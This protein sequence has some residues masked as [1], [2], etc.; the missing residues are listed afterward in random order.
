VSVA[1]VIAASCLPIVVA[2][3]MRWKM[4]ESVGFLYLSTVMTLLVIWRHRSNFSRL[5]SGTEQRFTRK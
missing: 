4:I 3:F 2:L 5:R 1:S